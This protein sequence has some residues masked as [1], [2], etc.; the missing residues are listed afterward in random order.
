MITFHQGK[1]LLIYTMFSCV[2]I[3]EPATVKPNL[4]SHL[5]CF[6][7]T[8]VVPFYLSQTPGSD[9]QSLSLSRSWPRCAIQH[10]SGWRT[11]CRRIPSTVR[12]WCAPFGSLVVFKGLEGWRDV[13]F[14]ALKLWGPWNVLDSHALLLMQGTVF[15]WSNDRFIVCVFWVPSSM[16]FRYSIFI[17]VTKV[18]SQILRLW[19]W[20]AKAA[21]VALLTVG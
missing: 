6:Y 4:D 13:N 10:C 16:N 12:M 15:S 18:V 11:L 9:S 14:G 17:R 20:I 19:F 1:V 3:K 8:N 21:T 5:F 2:S 7:G